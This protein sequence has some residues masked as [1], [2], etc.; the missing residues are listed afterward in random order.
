MN[1]KC[2]CPLKSNATDED[3]YSTEEYSGMK[4]EPGKCEGTNDIKKYKRD[5]KELWL[6]SCCHLPEDEEIK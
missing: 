3:M 5:D 1:H 6:C 2:E 4:H